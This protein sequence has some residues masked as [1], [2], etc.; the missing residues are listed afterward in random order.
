MEINLDM[1]NWYANGYVIVGDKDI[2]YRIY[3]E[4]VYDDN[5]DPEPITSYDDFEEALTWVYNS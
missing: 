4:H 3:D 1:G 5:D 2:G